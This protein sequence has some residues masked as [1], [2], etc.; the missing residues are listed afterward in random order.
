[1]T[2]SDGKVKCRPPDSGHGC[3]IMFTITMSHWIEPTPADISPLAGLELHPLLLQALARRGIRTPEAAHAFL[4]ADS[5]PPSLYPGLEKAVERIF[6]ATR[7]QEPIC[8]WGD[9]DVDGQTATALLVQTLQALGAEVSHYIPVRGRESHG[10]HI[11]SLQPILA[12]GTRLILTCDTGIGA[13]EAVDYIHANGAEVIISDHHEP[14]KSLPEAFAVINP[15]LLPE[16]HPLGSLAGVGVAYKLAEA[17]LEQAPGAAE[18][19][20]RPEE[21][22]DLV[23]LGL[24]ADVAQLSGETRSLAQRGIQALRTTPRTGLKVLAEL[25][26]ASLETLTEETIGFSLA[27][28]LNALGRLSDANPAV[29]LLLTRNAERARVL[30]VKIEGLNAQRRLLTSQ[31]Y[32]AAESLLR[33]NP[34][35]LSEPAILL[36]HPGWPGGVVGIVANKLVERY[37]KPAILLSESEDGLLRGS[38]RSVEGVH[39]T[40][41]IAAN[42]ALLGGFGG[43]PMAAGLSLEAEKLPEFRRG[44]GRAIER[45]L[46][47][48][49]RPEPGLQ[50]DAWLGL[51]ELDFPLAE[52]IE[53]LAPFGAGNP[54]LVL[55]TRGVSLE[56]AKP[57]GKGKEHLRLSVADESGRRQSLLWWG[58]AGEELPEE[59]H[60]FDIAYSLRASAFRGER[61]LSLQLIEYRLS[62]A[63]PVEVR[64]RRVEVADWRLHAGPLPPGAE[65]FA[66][67]EHKQKVDGRDRYNLAPSNELVVYTTP[68]GPAEWRMILEAVKPQKVYLLAN[69]PLAEKADEFL[70]RLGGLAKF[71]LNRRGGRVSLA[72]LAAASAQREIC[73]RLGLA[74]L[75]AGGHL[76][77]QEED[78]GLILGA[79]DGQAEPYLK[80]E[81]YTAIRGLL[82]ETAAYRAYFRRADKEAIARV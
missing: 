62:E 69:S 14:G 19:R 31:V 44:L 42:Q 25:A 59:G 30:A 37:H 56:S 33:A 50:I 58:G 18:G 52:A 81:L 27:P 5:L 8:I 29:E 24:I 71:A 12:R 79:G 64:A 28:R 68:P 40:E 17:L 4:E 16:G 10:V 45:Q 61:Q 2:A 3:C 75:E 53:K 1:M 74:W 20:L 73:V 77:V 72:E 63:M 36:S 70:T 80:S 7:S 65:V 26:G 57:I 15:K 39:I 9:F 13:H 78:S 38:A 48:L 76:R 23:A 60:R 22:L 6:L 55:A 67:G 11:E 51:D 66:E 82:A 47:A 54:P 43:H 49:P 21:L 32:Q 35:L 34:A 46:G 41:A